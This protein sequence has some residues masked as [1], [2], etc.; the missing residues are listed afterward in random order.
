VSSRTDYVVAGDGAGS[1]YDKAL[2]LGVPI[3]E[4]ARFDDFLS[5]GPAAV[6]G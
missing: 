1:K 4:A 3:I 5:G 6:A 2:A